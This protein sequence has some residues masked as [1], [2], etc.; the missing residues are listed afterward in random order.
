MTISATATMP[1]GMPSFLNVDGRIGIPHLL[2]PHDLIILEWTKVSG[3]CVSTAPGLEE[4][5]EQ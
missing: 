3:T 5:R 2:P 4:H 1:V